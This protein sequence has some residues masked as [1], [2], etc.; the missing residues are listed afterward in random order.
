MDSGELACGGRRRDTRCTGELRLASPIGVS[1]FISLLVGGKIHVL[2]QLLFICTI[3]SVIIPL[4]RE[5]EDP[6][7][8]KS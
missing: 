7:L 4:L 1:L 8:V 2:L 3:T 5:R 6:C